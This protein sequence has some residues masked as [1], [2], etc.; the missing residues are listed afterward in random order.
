MTSGEGRL[1]MVL[2][3]WQRESSHNSKPAVGWIPECKMDSTKE[4]QKNHRIAQCA[5]P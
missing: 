4:G 3:W 2:E 5:L 1:L